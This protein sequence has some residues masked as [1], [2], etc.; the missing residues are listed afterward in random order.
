MGMTGQRLG[1]SERW[2]ST[3]WMLV[4]VWQDRADHPTRGPVTLLLLGLP[5]SRGAGTGKPVEQ[6]AQDWGRLPPACQLQPFWVSPA[7]WD[8]G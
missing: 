3:G 5:W 7:L 2:P 8:T 6:P 4:P 1:G